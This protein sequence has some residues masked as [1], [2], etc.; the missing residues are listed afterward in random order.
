[1]PVTGVCSDASVAFGWFHE[2]DEEQ[3]TEGRTLLTAFAERRIE[4]FVLDLT[5]Y[6]IGNAAAR[7]RTALASTRVSEILAVL[8]ILAPILTPEPHELDLAATLAE[9]HGLTFYDASNAAVAQARGAALATLDH[10]LL[11]SGLGETPA[12]LVARLGL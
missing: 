12:Q 11:A 7:G 9:R 3:V 2:E 6:E 4:L 5:L 8:R 1:M 10:E